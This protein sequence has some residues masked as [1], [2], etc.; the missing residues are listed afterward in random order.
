MDPV[1]RTYLNSLQMIRFRSYGYILLRDTRPTIKERGTEGNIRDYNIEDWP[2]LQAWESYI[3][4]AGTLQATPSLQ[5][6]YSSSWASPGK[7]FQSW[8]DSPES[9]SE[10]SNTGVCKASNF[11]G[12][13]SLSFL[14]AGHNVYNLLYASHLNHISV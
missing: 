4:G 1:G 5:S 11:G 12:S 2:R 14:S 8:S 3:L 6:I 13:S 10:V 9:L 7:Q